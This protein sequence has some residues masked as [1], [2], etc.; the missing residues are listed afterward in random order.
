[1]IA[2]QMTMQM[3]A[4]IPAVVKDIVCLPKIMPKKNFVSEVHGKWLVQNNMRM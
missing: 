1:M 2:K 4:I 3:I